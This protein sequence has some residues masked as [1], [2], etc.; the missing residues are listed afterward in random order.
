MSGSKQIAN[1]RDQLTALENTPSSQ[2][3]T[4]AI[5]GLGLAVKYGGK[6]V[7]GINNLFKPKLKPDAT[8]ALELIPGKPIQFK[9]ENGIWKKVDRNGNLKVA[10]TAEAEAAEAAALKDARQHATA[11]SPQHAPAP[12]TTQPGAAGGAAN[13]TM[14]DLSTL[15]KTAE[16]VKQATELASKLTRY[17]GLGL[18]GFN[19]REFSIASEKG[20]YEGMERA[21]LW[22]LAGAVGFVAP[23]TTMAMA[24]T[25]AVLGLTV[26]IWGSKPF[27]EEEKQKI[28]ETAS[29]YYGEGKPLDP[30]KIDPKYFEAVKKQYDEYQ[31]NPK[32]TGGAAKPPTATGSPAASGTPAA[33]STSTVTPVAATTSAATSP[34]TSTPTSN[35]AEELRAMLKAAGLGK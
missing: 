13:A 25:A 10:T 35:D 34:V 3:V 18:A 4:E 15:A 33:A 22:A 1:L 20:D 28:K 26:K 16:V 14:P 5:P 24:T 23:K 12:A 27:T 17:I 8:A 19:S 9:L 7:Q 2:T 30:T 6:V 32:P 31:K 29:F 21:G 11:A